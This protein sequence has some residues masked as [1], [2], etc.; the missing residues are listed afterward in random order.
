MVINS[1][2]LGLLWLFILYGLFIKYTTKK[3]HKNPPKIQ[4]LRW[5]NGDHWKSI[6]LSWF[7]I[8][9]LEKYK[10]TI[11][12]YDKV[13]HVIAGFIMYAVSGGDLTIATIYNV[14]WETK[15]AVCDYEV[16]PKVGG[17]GASWRDFTASQFGIYA[18]HFIWTSLAT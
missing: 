17:E 13:Q 12:K 3:T 5:S 10:L 14:S 18:L 16:F 7:S 11:L 1:I 4:Y 9:T 2:L 8:T 6:E 15:D